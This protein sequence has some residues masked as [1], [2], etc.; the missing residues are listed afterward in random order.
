MQI[1]MKP[2][3]FVH[4]KEGDVPRHWSLSDLEGS[5]EV[6]KK[7]MEGLKD[8]K[9]GQ[10][11]ILLFNFNRSA[12]FSSSFLTQRPPTGKEKRGV[13]SICSPRR[14]NP[15]GMSVLDVLD[16]C[17]N[18]IKVKGVDMLDRTPILDIKPFIKDKDSCPSFRQG[19][20]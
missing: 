4:T 14:P 10:K 20:D 12:E 5:L 3:G 2:I 9:K 11:I 1:I 18:I 15:I 16:I 19:N 8:I 17:E 7:Y 13:F 6:Y